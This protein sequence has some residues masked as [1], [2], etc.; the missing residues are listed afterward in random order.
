ME[1]EEIVIHK[2]K[3]HN[4]DY[5]NRGHIVLTIMPGLFIKYEVFKVSYQ[6]GTPV[7]DEFGNLGFKLVDTIVRK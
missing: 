3:F 6:T 5:P 7:Y 1:P 4:E 2:I